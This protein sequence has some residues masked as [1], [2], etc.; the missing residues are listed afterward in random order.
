[1][2]HLKPS[3]PSD[4]TNKG[5]FTVAWKYSL[6]IILVENPVLILKQAI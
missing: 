4:L 3:L 5:F 1:M 6:E 2:H